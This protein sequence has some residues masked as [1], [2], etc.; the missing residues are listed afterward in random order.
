VGS[1]GQPWAGSGQWE[2]GWATTP[3]RP[4]LSFQ[5]VAEMAASGL[6]FKDRLDEVFNY[7]AWKER[8]MLV[9]T[10]NDIWEFSNSIMAPST[11]LKD[12]ATQKLKD[13]KA[14]CMILDGVKDHL[15]PHLSRKNSTMN[16]W[17]ALKRFFQGK[18][19]NRKM[20]LREKLR[21]TKMTG[22][23]TVTTS[24]PDPTGSR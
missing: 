24:H 11:V 22:S 5:Q 21:D 14:R 6:Q 20:V 7:S 13:V 1:P 2:T 16:M 23:Y 8:I 4:N 12:L 18:N 15:I 17:E 3:S 9:V 19:E 10:E